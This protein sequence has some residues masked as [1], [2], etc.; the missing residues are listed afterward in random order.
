MTDPTSQPGQP[1]ERSPYER[2]SD[3]LPVNDSRPADPPPAEA[4]VV[5]PSETWPTA[6]I[7]APGDQHPATVLPDAPGYSVGPRPTAVL[8]GNQVP[9]TPYPTAVLPGDQVPVAVIPGTEPSG[10]LPITAPHSQPF[11]AVGPPQP[12][13]PVPRKP[14][15]KAR[16]GAVAVVEPDE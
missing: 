11:P 15:P 4:T 16:S 14:R 12:Y 3:P 6:T 10:P 8:P 13:V 1:T 5:V 9:G 2:P 7:P